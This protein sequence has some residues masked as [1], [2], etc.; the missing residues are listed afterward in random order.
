MFPHSKRQELYLH[1]REVFQRWPPSDMTCLKETLDSYL[2][3]PHHKSNSVPEELL[4]KLVTSV[5]RN[6]WSCNLKCV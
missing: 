5:K 4:S 3:T 2:R 6:I 1:A